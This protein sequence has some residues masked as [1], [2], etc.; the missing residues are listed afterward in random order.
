ML[1]MRGKIATKVEVTLNTNMPTIV[2][3]MMMTMSTNFKAVSF[4]SHNLFND[5]ITSQY[6]KTTLLLII[7]ANSNTVAKGYFLYSVLI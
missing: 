3:K 5:I 2:T 1:T 4:C 7:A 6:A